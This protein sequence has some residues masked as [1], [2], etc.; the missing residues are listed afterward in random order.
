MT[1]T[2]PHVCSLPERKNCGASAIYM[3][4]NCGAVYRLHPIVRRWYR[5]EP[6]PV[7]PGT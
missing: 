2:A 4:M 6:V 5:Y 7:T 1:T 3:C